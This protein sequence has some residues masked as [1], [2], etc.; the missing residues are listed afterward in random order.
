VVQGV[1]ERSL[2]RLARSVRVPPDE[3]SPG[4]DERSAARAQAR[5]HLGQ[6]IETGLDALRHAC[7]DVRGPHGRGREQRVDGERRRCA[8]L[9]ERDGV[10]I[11]SAPGS[12]KA[13]S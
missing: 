1:H 10:T 6:L 5:R 4:A 11:F 9:V 8:L 12:S 7:A 13:L 2:R 3:R